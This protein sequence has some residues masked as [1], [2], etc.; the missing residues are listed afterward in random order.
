MPSAFLISEARAQIA[1]SNNKEVHVRSR[2]RVKLTCAVD[3]AHGSTSEAGAVFWYLN[4][5]ALD[6][7][8]Q[9]GPGRGVQVHTEVTP[10]RE[11]VSTLVIDKADRRHAGK[12]TCSPSYAKSDTVTLHV[13][14]GE[15]SSQVQAVS[16][17]H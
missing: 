12:F 1:G 5:Q 3:L 6:W 2:S 15:S 14:D 16:Q 7:L 11:L 17:S 10:G 4:G 9:T 8:G 13:V